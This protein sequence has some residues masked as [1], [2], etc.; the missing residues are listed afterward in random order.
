METISLKSIVATSCCLFMISSSCFADE[1]KIGAGAAPANA[2]I[3]PIKNAFEA[4]GDTII[5]YEQ[6]P[7]LAMQELI[8]GAV[9][10]AAAG[11]TFDETVNMLKKEGVSVNTADF[12]HVVVGK[13]IAVAMINKNNPISKL[14]KEQL[15]GIMT[16]KIKN[17]K[18]V[19]GL[20]SEI[21]IVLGKLTPGQNS[22]FAK[23]IMNGEAYSSEVLDATTGPEVRS[24]IVANPE[25][26]GV[27]AISVAD[28]T[29]KV[30]EQPEASGDMVFI[31]KGKPSAKSQKLIDFVLGDGKKLIK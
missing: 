15:H 13:T 10:I 8:K 3:K 7:K 19:G 12:Q 18:E 22:L 26:I 4:K 30:P 31:T 24:A 20:D 17:W 27:S 11:I 25:A 21:L 9:D 2:I 28:S 5:L 23:K 16:G 6:G 29:V 14:S 1:I